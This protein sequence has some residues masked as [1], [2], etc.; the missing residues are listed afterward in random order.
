MASKR[1]TAASVKGLDAG[2]KLRFLWDDLIPGFGLRV[3][4]KGVKAYV[5]MF[6]NWSGKQ[7]MLTIGRTNVWSVSAARKR[8]LGL[9]RS[10]DSGNDPLAKKDEF[11]KSDTMNILF[12]R[13]LNEHSRVRNK[14]STV[15]ANEENIERVLGPRFGKKRLIEMNEADITSWLA[16]MRHAPH[17][18]NRC[19]QV[20]KK[21]L[22]L[23]AGQWKL[24]EENPAR[25]VEPLPVTKEE[26]TRRALDAQ[27][28][29]RLGKV[30][31][32][33]NEPEA[34][35]AAIRLALLTACRHGELLALRWRDVDL[36]K[37]EFRVVDAKSG[38][39]SVTINERAFEILSE[40]KR[41]SLTENVL[42]YDGAALTDTRLR[43][44][45]D[46]IR[47]AAGIENKRF[48]DLRHTAATAA[49]EQ[50]SSAWEVMVLL[51]HKNITTSQIY[52]TELE[53]REHQ[54]AASEKL[55]KGIGA[56]LE[57]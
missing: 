13:Y 48:H 29:G 55:G 20:L 14:E 27:Q 22:T 51:G 54:R 21:V 18:A 12:E 5:F 41:S 16:G 23:C 4:P 33:G 47:K 8:A 46:R 10:V 26:L 7:R 38:P 39:R 1:I 15:E 56:D 2:N 30:L 43:G 52:V 50:G 35:S 40:L 37:R 9:R 53:N 49:V 24:I 45:W 44:S 17:R 31:Q 11:N 34:C 25:Y 36:E 42:E 3:T 19:L 57:G 32:Y 28:R 6:R